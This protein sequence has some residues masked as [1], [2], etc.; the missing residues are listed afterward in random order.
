[1]SC[2]GS[3]EVLFEHIGQVLDCSA[4]A[5]PRAAA[6]Y[7]VNRVEFASCVCPPLKVGEQLKR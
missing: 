2:R 7:D 6:I 4:F 3:A 1:M 5:I